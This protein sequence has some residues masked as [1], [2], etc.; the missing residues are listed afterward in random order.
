MAPGKRSPLVEARGKAGL[1]A[2]SPECLREL[3]KENKKNVVALPLM[4]GWQR[5]VLL[6]TILNSPPCCFCQVLTHCV[7]WH[8]NSKPHGAIAV[9]IFFF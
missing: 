7:M 6:D 4:C 9:A 5:H 3:K 8:W 1:R 2:S